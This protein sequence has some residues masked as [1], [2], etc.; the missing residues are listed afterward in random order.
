[1]GRMTKVT[2][3]AAAA[4]LSLGVAACGDDDDTNTTTDTTAASTDTTG[5]SAEGDN[6][7]FCDAVVDFNN[8]AFQVDISEDTSTEDIKAAGESLAPLSAALSENAPEDLADGAQAIDDFVQPLVAGD[9][10]PFNAGQHVRDLLGLLGRR[11]ESLR[12]QGGRCGGERLRLHGSGHDRG[13]SR[14]VCL[15]E[16]Q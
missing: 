10:E 13:G 1:M 6:A 12:V 15:L 8:A 2:A 11:H 5:A 3:A 9:A 7:A 4:L 16:R 14:V